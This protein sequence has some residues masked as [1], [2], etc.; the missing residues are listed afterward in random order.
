MLH[1][2]RTGRSLH[3]GTGRRGLKINMSKVIQIILKTNFNTGI[4]LKMYGF[5]FFVACNSLH[6][7]QLFT[8]LRCIFTDP[9][10]MKPGQEPITKSLNVKHVVCE[11]SKVWKPQ[12]AHYS[13][14]MQ[15]CVFKLDHHCPW[16][17]NCVGHRN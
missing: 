14:D 2:S 6:I 4:P 15:C 16:I 1:I 10:I 12:R 9:G 13:R 11:K 8:Y 7:I 17:N 5:Y 3:I